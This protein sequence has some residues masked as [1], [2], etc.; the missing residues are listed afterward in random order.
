MSGISRPLQYEGECGIGIVYRSD[1][2]VRPH[3]HKAMRYLVKD[4]QPLRFCEHSICCRLEII[5][6][7]YIQVVRS[8]ARIAL[9]LSVYLYSCIFYMSDC[10]V[11]SYQHQ[12]S[13]PL[14]RLR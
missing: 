3:V 13:M 5:F 4:V 8:R 14:S 7:M 1:L 10:S 12:K 11:L 9:E 6:C 2:E